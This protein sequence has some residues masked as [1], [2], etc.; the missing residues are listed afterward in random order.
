MFVVIICNCTWQAC[1]ERTDTNAM[2]R[3]G[4]ETLV[5]DIGDMAGAG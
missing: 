3:M 5:L 2:M 4:R 1:E